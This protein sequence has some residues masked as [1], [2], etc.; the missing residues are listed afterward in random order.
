LTGSA[1]RLQGENAALALRQRLNLGD[2]AAD[3]ESIAGRRG[4]LVFRRDFGPGAPDGMYVFD[5]NDAIVVVNGS[6][7][8]QRQ[9]F[10][11]AH[12]L[13]HHE[14]H[15]VRGPMQLI[16]VNVYANDDG[17]GAKDPDE[18]AANAFAAH[19]LLPRTALEHALG[20]RRNRQ[21]GI[22]ELVELVKRFR[23][24]WETA[25]WRLYNEKFVRKADRERLLGEPRTATLTSHGVDD[26]TYALTGPAVP[27]ALASDA[28]RLWAAW[29]ITD[30][31]LAQILERSVPDALALMADWE[32]V[33][34]DRADAAA[35]AGERLLATAG[36]DLAAIA[37]AAADLE[38]DQ[39]A[40]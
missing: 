40:I 12:E 36:V 29:H 31:R 30:E 16:D 1:A 21:I 27:S 10:T 32:V 13:G 2:E 20:T 26:R 22:A 3:L 9:R 35:D 37:T 5:G 28:A 8:A 23:V 24:S 19:L 4:A 17:S 7:P 33:R 38:D 6:K 11:L 39:D 34:D 25:C 14:L 15:R 18:V